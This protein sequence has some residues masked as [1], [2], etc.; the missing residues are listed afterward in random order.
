[1]SLW[2]CAPEISQDQVTVD[3]VDLSFIGLSAVILIDQ[4]TVGRALDL[5]DLICMSLARS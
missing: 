4:Y 1:M 5:V 3:L 2:I